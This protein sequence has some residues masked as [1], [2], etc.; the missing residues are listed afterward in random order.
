MSESEVKNG[1]VAQA[2]AE[3]QIGEAPKNWRK[4]R[5]SECR[6][7]F[8]VPIGDIGNLY[9]N[10]K[11][12]H[13][14]ARLLGRDEKFGYDRQFMYRRCDSKGR[15]IG[16][17]LPEDV[18]VGDVFEEAGGSWKNIYR[19]YCVVRAIVENGI[20]VEDIG[21]PDVLKILEQ[22]EVSE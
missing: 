22:A 14:A 18:A 9:A 16:Y 13:W 5:V 21:E 17:V 7:G 11:V 19:G 15:T 10:N 2:A 3:Q 12:K 4:L 20:F 8:W 6:Y 1:S